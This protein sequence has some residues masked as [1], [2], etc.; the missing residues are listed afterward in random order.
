VIS[1][2]DELMAACDAVLASTNDTF[3]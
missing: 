3:G 2:F 1:H